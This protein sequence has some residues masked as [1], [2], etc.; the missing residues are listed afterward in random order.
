MKTLQRA[1]FFLSFLIFSASSQ[2][3]THC[4]S[5]AAQLAST[6]SSASNSTDALVRIKLRI[7]TYQ[8]TAQAPFMF[9]QKA[10]NQTVEI[11]GG[12]SGANGACT[13]MSRDPTQTVL[14]GATTKPA[15]WLVAG[16][17]PGLP[18]SPA[19]ANSTLHVHHLTLKNANFT[20]A[21]EVNEDEYDDGFWW[22]ANETESAC[23][24]AL[25]GGGSN[26]LALEY[27]DIR[28]CN[29]PNNGDAL[30]HIEN[31]GATLLMRN[32][33]GRDGSAALN[34]GVF[35]KTTG[36]N[37]VSRLSQISL[38]NMRTLTIG[39]GLLTGLDLRAYYGGAVHLSNSV[40]W[41]VTSQGTPITTLF[42]G[43]G[44]WNADDTEWE[45]GSFGSVYLKR[46][47]TGGTYLPSSGNAI[48]TL[49]MSSGDPLFVAPGNPIPRS[50]SPL[51]N[52]GIDNPEGGAGTYDLAGKPR[53]QGN[54]V[55]VGAFEFQPANQA[56]SMGNASIQT[57]S[58]QATGS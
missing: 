35:I 40:V 52:T 6:L 23:L 46:V 16:V 57:P 28:T 56:P 17:N 27:L 30:A 44:R 38:T 29:A 25:V 49:G 34:G 43:P 32:I 7:G 48:Q 15:L 11:S 9:W 10:S 3:A 8:A 53:V 54:H 5:N 24:N 4:V 22:D 31:I 36:S 33:A 13:D 19:P 26:Q 2:A 14:L 37:A 21:Y 45:T 58:S 18:G 51:V 42:V 55:D 12:W 47:H 1:L 50:D 41:D 20:P 39:A